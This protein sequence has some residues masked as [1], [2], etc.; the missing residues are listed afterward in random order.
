MRKEENSINIIWDSV[1]SKFQLEDFVD[2]DKIN[3]LWTSFHL[4][5]LKK[6]IMALPANSRFLEAGCGLGQWCFYANKLGH[7]AVG[8]DIAEDIINRLNEFI[9]GKPEYKNMRFLVDDLCNSKLES[10]QFDLILSLGVIEHFRDSSLMLEE[11]RRLLK[12]GG[13][14]FISVPNIFAMQTITRPLTELFGIWSIGYEKSFSP[15]SLKKQ[16]RDAGFI[17][18]RFGIL[19]SGYIFGRF[20][21][22]LP[23]VGRLVKKIGY[24]IETRQKLFGLY[25]YVIATK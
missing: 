18:D 16:I 8:A 11:L 12:P 17:L 21:N 23:F 2:V 19:P 25:I 20:L 5:I 7:E 22:S 14:V 3:D 4:E 6:Q 10:N 24:W 15:A 1:W 9:R 13:K